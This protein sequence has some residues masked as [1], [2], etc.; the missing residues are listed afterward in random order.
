[1]RA[2]PTPTANVVIGEA[3][4]SPTAG[5]AKDLEID[6]FAIPHVGISRIRG[7][8]TAI[9]SPHLVPSVGPL[10]RGVAERAVV[11]RAPH[12]RVGSDMAG[13]VVELCH[14]VA[15]VQI[16]PAVRVGLRR[17]VSDR[18][19]V[20]RP[21]DAAIVAE[22]HAPIVAAVIAGLGHDHVMVRMGG[23]VA[24]PGANGRERVAAVRA[25][26]KIDAADEQ[27]ID[28]CRIAGPDDVI[29][30]TLCSKEVGRLAIGCG[31]S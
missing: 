29:V 26:P 11:L 23:L 18:G 21:V 30:P 24:R 19:D 22:I 20:V 27:Q 3:R 8:V 7:D 17:V 4:R 15:V 31:V 13:P 5:I 2:V 10:G 12:D 25:P 28:I 6:V 14:A 9:A 16:R 1:M